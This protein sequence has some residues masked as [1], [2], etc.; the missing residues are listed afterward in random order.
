MPAKKAPKSVTEQVQAFVKKMVDN[1]IDRRD[2]AEA[3]RH[4]IN[5]MGTRRHYSQE[6]ADELCE[7]MR[8]GETIHQMSREEHLPSFECVSRWRKLHP[9]FDQAIARARVDQMHAWADQIISLADDVEGNY[10]KI[11]VAL[12]DPALQRTEKAGKVTFSYHRKHVTRAQLMIDTRKWLMAR[13]DPATFADRKTVDVAITYEDKDDE[14]LLAELREAA[15]K[16]GVTAAEVAAWL[17]DDD[18]GGE[19]A[20]H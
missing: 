6:I 15:Q 3:L 13:F 12:D 11:E 1:K 16:A 8:H 17:G 9:E 7:R 10:S 18:D 19:V 20:I 14:E 4:A 5:N 2:I